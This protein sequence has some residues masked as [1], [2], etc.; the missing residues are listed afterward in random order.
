MTDSATRSIG[1]RLQLAARL[2]R[3]RIAEAIQDLGLFPGQEQVLLALNSEAKLSVGDLA[4]IMQVRPPTISKTI[5]RLTQQ[6]LIQR[7]E[8]ETDARRSRIRLTG[9]GARRASE[10]SARLE[11]VDRD[12]TSRLDEKDQ[13]RLRKLLK[14]AIK[15]LSADGTDE[16]APGEAGEE[17]DS[18]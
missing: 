18:D 3:A 6:G 1:Y 8:H 14:R 4:R 12:L 7:E 11:K 10:L 13:R 2:H 15:A 16:P 9:E 17:A 5:Q